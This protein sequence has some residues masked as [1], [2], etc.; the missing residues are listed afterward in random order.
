MVVEDELHLNDVIAKRLLQEHYSVDAC[1]NGND[2]LDYIRCAEYDAVILDIMLPGCS[3]LEVLREMRIKQNRTPVLL[4]TAKDS[5]DDRVTGL[6][7]GADDYLVKPFALEEL[8]ARIRVMIRRSQNLISSR[9][10]IGDMI[11]DCDRRTVTRGGTPVVLSSR[12]FDVL[13][14]LA[15]NTG[16]VLSRDKISQHLWNYDYEGSSNVIDVYI[17]YL[18]RKLDEGHTRRLIH[19]VRGAGYVMR[20]E[21]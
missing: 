10:K 8:L 1:K 19:T 15:R 21:Q 7:A 6:D 16:I 14:Y 5:I 12:E 9:I 18:R 11:I 17:R 13:E 2:A 4:L 20:E 3:G